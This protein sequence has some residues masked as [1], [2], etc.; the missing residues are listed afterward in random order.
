V[1]AL[2]VDDE[3]LGRRELRRLLEAHPEVEVIGEAAT[4]EEAESLLRRSAP[5]VVFLDIR[6][7]SASGM[8]LVPHVPPQTAIVFVTA[9]DRYAVRAFELNALDYLLKPVEP[10]RLALTLKRVS[11]PDAPWSVR[12]EAG[13]SSPVAYE[14]S[15]WLF[16]R[17]R[18]RVEFVAVASVTH[19]TSDGDY[20]HVWT[21]DGT[22]RLAKISLNAWERRLPPGDFLRIHRSAIVNLRFVRSVEP[23]TNHGYW[24]H[25]R[26]RNTPLTMSRRHASRMRQRLG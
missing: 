1:R 10:E 7:G 11:G 2:I 9:F 17:D 4:R 14:P 3:P 18:D 22:D 5:D 25:V 13:T 12:S 6:L 24:V 23:A 26:G 20:T 21:A 19:L 16:L 15:D 8:D